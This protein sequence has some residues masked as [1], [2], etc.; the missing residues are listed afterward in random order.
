MSQCCF[1]FIFGLLSRALSSPCA[2]FFFLYRREKTFLGGICASRVCVCSNLQLRRGQ[3]SVYERETLRS[4]RE[5]A[6]D[7]RFTCQRQRR[8][9]HQKKQNPK[10]D[11]RGAFHFLYSPSSPAFVFCV[12]LLR[13]NSLSPFQSRK[14]RNLHP[15]W[16]SRRKERK[17]PL[18]A[19]TNARPL[20]AGSQE[21]EGVVNV[22]QVFIGGVEERV[23]FDIGQ[24]HGALPLRGEE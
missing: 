4:E 14:S 23:E 12:C 10:K 3:L 9:P 20:F 18:A 21:I 6:R 24:F 8:T 11:K 15:T 1:H 2:P 7:Y 22:R 5:S 17:A 16:L 13:R 19:T